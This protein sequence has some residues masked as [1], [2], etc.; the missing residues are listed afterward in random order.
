MPGVE[1]LDWPPN[2]APPLFPFPAPWRDP[3]ELFDPEFG[4]G[5][6]FVDLEFSRGFAPPAAWPP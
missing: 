4:M 5:V 2:C 1:D 3:S 6:L